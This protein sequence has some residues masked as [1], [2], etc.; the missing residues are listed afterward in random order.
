[1]IAAAP[2]C[3]LPADPAHVPVHAVGNLLIMGTVWS[4]R[5][6]HTPMYLFL[7]ALSSSKVLYTFAIIPRMLGVLLSTQHSISF[8]ACAGQMFSF[9]MCCYTHPFL[10]IVMGYDH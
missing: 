5:S 8:V 1:M 3:L 4:K 7:C 6:L 10:L 2:A 9:Y